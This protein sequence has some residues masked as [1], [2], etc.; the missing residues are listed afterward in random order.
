MRRRLIAGIGLLLLTTGCLARGMG[1]VAADLPVTRPLPSQSS[2]DAGVPGVHRSGGADV[3]RPAG[4]VLIP[5]LHP[6]DAMIIARERPGRRVR[7]LDA[8]LMKAGPVMALM[9]W[10]LFAMVIAF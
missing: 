10:S 8:A 4:D 5:V 7:Q 9:N 1:R 6:P 2:G 3:H